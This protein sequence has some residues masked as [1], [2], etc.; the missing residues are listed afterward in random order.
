MATNSNCNLVLIIVQ[1][2]PKIQNSNCNLGPILE[3]NCNLDFFGNG[4][5]GVKNCSIG[6]KKNIVKQLLTS[7]VTQG[8]TQ[9]NKQ[10]I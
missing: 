10:K 2:W 6:A 9:K 3:L 7:K 8:G 4:V 1:Q 5:I